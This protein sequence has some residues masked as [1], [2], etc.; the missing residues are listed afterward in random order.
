MRGES[1]ANDNGEFY[2]PAGAILVASIGI[3]ASLSGDEA[4]RIIVIISAAEGDG[5]ISLGLFGFLMALPML[6]APLIGAVTDR[7]HAHPR[8]LF[9]GATGLGAA[10]TAVLWIAWDTAAQATAVYA[11][12]FFLELSALAVL[13]AWQSFVPEFA[14][15]N[16]SSLKKVISTSSAV[17]AIGPLVGPLMVGLLLGVLTEKQILLINTLTCVIAMLMAQPALKRLQDQRR[18][19]ISGRL[20]R[21]GVLS[22]IRRTI[23]GVGAV[24]RLDAVRAP[25]IVLSLSNAATYLIYFALPVYMAASGYDPSEIALAMAVSLAGALVGSLLGGCFRSNSYVVRL[26][27]VEPVLRALGIVVI[28][29][30]PSY[31]G[32]LVGATIFAVPQGLG[33]VARSWLLAHATKVGERGSINGGYRFVS[34][35]LLP[36]MPFLAV[37]ISSQAEGQSFLLVCAAALAL[38]GVV[39]LIDRRFVAVVQAGL[40]SATV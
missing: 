32:I 5:G 20:S 15:P 39:P 27:V 6:A 24:F 17:L 40:A 22:I 30:S 18:M 1:A 11:A 25:L 12:G 36:L 26:I 35:A 38:C 9:T 34:R 14:P 8:A 29:I 3:M 4:L 19:S 31:V 2:M 37:G 28:A 33:R 7:F 13:L 21:V 16:S 23:H 10:A